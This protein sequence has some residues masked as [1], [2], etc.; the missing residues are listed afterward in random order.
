VGH[1]LAVIGVCK[2]SSST[3]QIA[4]YVD[5]AAPTVKSRSLNQWRTELRRYKF[6]GKFKIG[7]SAAE[8]ALRSL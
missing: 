4:N 1:P 2:D 7:T 8:T 5:N 6:E 3:D